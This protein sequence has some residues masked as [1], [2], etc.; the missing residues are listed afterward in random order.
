M[1]QNKNNY[2]NLDLHISVLNCN[3]IRK[4]I[5]AFRFIAQYENVKL[6]QYT[7]SA[8]LSNGVTGMQT[9]YPPIK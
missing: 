6:K 5:N 9:K 2:N 8:D 1:F 3:Y 4:Q 7:A